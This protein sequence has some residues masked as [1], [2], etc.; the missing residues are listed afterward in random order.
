M[1]SHRAGR[2]RDANL[3]V[4]SGVDCSGKSTQVALLIDRLVERGEKPVYFWSRV[5]YT[6]LFNALKASLRKVV[7]KTRLPVGE[8]PQRDRFLA[9]GWTQRLWLWIAFADMILQTAIRLRWLRWAGRTIVCDR[10]IDDSENDLIMNFG[11]RAPQQA[12]WRWVKAMAAKPDVSILLELPFEEA[13]RRSILKN[14]PFADSAE[15]RLRRGDLYKVMRETG[16]YHVIDARKSVG[17]IAAVVDSLAFV[18]C[19]S[20]ILSNAVSI[21]NSLPATSVTPMKEVPR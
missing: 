3:I 11:E 6:P 13:L 20:A 2:K 7:G 15:R 5:G 9:G 17:E 4:F 18:D 10:Y 16:R 14:E 19:R 21:T 12:A 1:Q 8:S